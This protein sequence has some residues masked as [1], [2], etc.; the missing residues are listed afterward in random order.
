MIISASRRTDIPAYFSEWFINRIKEKY[1]TV[2]NPFN[3][4]QVSFVDLSP[5][6]VDVIVFWTRNAQPLLKN[7]DILDNLGY[8]YYFQY[9]INN[10]P[11]LYEKS[12]PSL[13]SAIDTFIKLSKR[14]GTGKVIWRYDPII[15]TNDLTPQYHTNN[16]NTIFS[17]IGDYTKRIVISIVDNYNKTNR[18][19]DSL[20]VNY[21]NDQLEKPQLLELL[22]KFVKVA[23]QN[24]LEVQSCAEDIDLEQIGIKHGKCIDD[25][26]I[27]KEFNVGL[28][29][30]KDKSQRLACGC[31]DSK[32]IGMNN[33]CL[34]GCE[35]CYATVSN[36]SAIHNK[37]KHNPKFSSVI[38]HELNDKMIEQINDFKSGKIKKSTQYELKF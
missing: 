14:L 34:M 33:T 13:E 18:R 5:D 29:F 17:K 2:P 24:G 35:Y 6:A 8:K 26:L 3:L 20:N 23:N 28:K 37:K 11:K 12:N 38:E 1:C 16:F 31:T 22:E 10:Y 15:F 7:L 30:K 36:N 25:E 19:M 4:K 9:T 27:K 32:D 21:Q